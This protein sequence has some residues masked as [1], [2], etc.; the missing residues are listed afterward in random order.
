MR[1]YKVIVRV[2]HRRYSFECMAVSWYEAWLSAAEEFGGS[3][4][5]SVRPVI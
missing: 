4:V 5:L 3:N 2:N 1:G